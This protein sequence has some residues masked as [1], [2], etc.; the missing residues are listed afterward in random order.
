MKFSY[1]K[2][3]QPLVSPESVLDLQAEGDE[4]IEILLDRGRESNVAIHED[5]NIV[6]TTH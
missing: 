2:G 6:P 3:Q 5:G 1:E 4:V